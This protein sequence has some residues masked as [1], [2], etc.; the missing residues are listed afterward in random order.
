MKTCVR[1][2]VTVGAMV[3]LF[4]VSAP[5]A[6]QEQPQLTTADGWYNYGVPFPDL[7]GPVPRMPDGKPD[8]SGQWATLRRADITA[9]RIPGYVPELPYTEWGQRQWDNYDPEVNGDYAG[10]CMPFGW[11]RIVHGPRLT[12]FVHK[13]D[14]LVVLAEQ[15]TWFHIVFLDGR[16]HDPNMY[17]TWWGDSIGHW[18]DDTL[19]VETTNM[20]G[21]IKLDTIG[22]PISSEATFTQTFTRVNFGTIEH[23]F[24]V[25]DPKTYTEPFTIYN[26]WPVEPLTIRML[27][28]SCM[29]G[30]LENLITGSITPW[31]PPVGEDAP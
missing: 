8:L 24:T 23:T 19:V 21:Y 27:E 22:H 18:E 4:V 3:A 14:M 2:T 17:P 11:S 20:S 6:A 12:R 16:P 10:S 26:T 9:D 15:G 30:N 31:R 25:D 1:L 28:Y 7:D 29:E 13:E 5:G